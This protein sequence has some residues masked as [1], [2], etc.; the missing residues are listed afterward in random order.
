M[1]SPT[2]IPQQQTTFFAV[3]EA[4]PRGDGTYIVRAQTPRQ[5]LSTSQAARATG[6]DQ[7]T[8]RRYAAEGYVLARRCGKRK[9]QIEAEDLYKKCGRPANHLE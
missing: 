3:L 2:D 5:W 9:Y 4:T 8:L 1:P 6:L 7:A